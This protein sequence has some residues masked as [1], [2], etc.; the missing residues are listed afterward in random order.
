M[1]LSENELL[2][3]VQSAYRQF[4]ST[5]TAVLKVVS[6]VSTAMDRGQITLLGMFDLSAT[7]DMVDHAILLKRLNVSFGIQG[8]ALDWFVS[9]LSG[10]SQQVSVHGIL[11]SSFYL[12]FGVLQGSVLGPVLFLLYTADL[13]A[14]V[15]GFG[16][17]VVK[18]KVCM[19]MFKC[20]EGLAPTYLVAFCTKGSAVSG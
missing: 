6:D 2:P 11:A 4:F 9:Y 10:R 17:S 5:E 8:N 20:L 12:D 13:V 14:L 15:Q 16:L 7:F 1:Y 18:Y 19:L 3:S